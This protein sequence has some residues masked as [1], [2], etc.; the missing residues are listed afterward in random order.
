MRSATRSTACACRFLVRF[1]TELTGRASQV[2]TGPG[3][4]GGRLTMVLRWV[5]PIVDVPHTRRCARR[6]SD[7]INPAAAAGCTEATIRNHPP[8]VDGPAAGRSGR[9]VGR[10]PSWRC[11]RVSRRAV[12]PRRLRNQNR[13]DSGCSRTSCPPISLGCGWCGRRTAARSPTTGTRQATKSNYD[14]RRSTSRP[15]RVVMDRRL[16][17]CATRLVTRQRALL[18]VIELGIDGRDRVGVPG[19]TERHAR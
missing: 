1:S 19:Q 3:A 13:P 12:A 8:R 7:G 18:V 10:V 6:R 16:V 4:R 17:R 5:T 15:A 11:A 2:E 14:L 9:D